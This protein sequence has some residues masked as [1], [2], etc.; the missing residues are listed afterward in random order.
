VSI[1]SDTQL[2]QHDGRFEA[3]RRRRRI[4]LQLANEMERILQ[5]EKHA[6]ALPT[7]S[8]IS[9]LDPEVVAFIPGG[10]KPLLRC[11]NN[12]STF[13]GGSHFFPFSTSITVS[14]FQG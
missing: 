3:I 9:R 4:Q 1:V 6:F 8:S 10:R 13:G 14:R 7:G 11:W 5:K 2:F 12:S